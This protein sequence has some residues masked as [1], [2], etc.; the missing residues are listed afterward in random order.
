[1]TVLVLTRRLDPTAD[2][3]IRELQQRGTPVLRCDPGDFPESVELAARVS[4]AGAVTGMLRVGEREVE[5]SEIASVYHRRPTPHRTHPRLND[6]E[7]AWTAREAS[8]GFGGVLAALD[9][10]W[11]N[12]PDRNRAA[13]HKPRQ[14]V[15]AARAG[16]TVPESLVTNSAY[17]ARAFVGAREG[18]VYK[19]MTGGPGTTA[20]LVRASALYTTLVASDEITPGV[21]R[22]AHLFQEWVDKAYEVRLT[23]VG[24]RLFATRIDAHGPRARTDWRSDYRNL[25]YR[26]VETPEDVARAVRRLMSGFQL[27]YG[28]LDFVV[29]PGGRW[30]FLELNPDGQWGWLQLATGQPIAAALADH[31]KESST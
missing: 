1:V 23:V 2:L 26:A 19:A 13:A 20:A 15:A 11:V 7:S 8:A 17:T 21:A 22:T 10:P 30:V 28:A 9:R 16:L 14:L 12:H 4:A 5:L 18:T 29:T 25:S 3:V 6:S 31:L 27:A 24:Q